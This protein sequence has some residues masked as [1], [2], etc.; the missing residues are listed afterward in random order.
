MKLK[1]FTY[2]TNVQWIEAKRGLLSAP[3][4][5]N[6]EVATPPEF[7]GHQGKWTPEE[8]FV[9]SLNTCIMTTFLYY[10]EKEGLEFLSYESPGEGVLERTE[11]GLMFSEIEITPKISVASKDEVEKAKSLLRLAERNCFISNSLKSK[12]EVVSEISAK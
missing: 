2:K 5:P 12:V 10:A 3:G 6:I 11:N 7:K 8:L 1:K 9:A 4:K